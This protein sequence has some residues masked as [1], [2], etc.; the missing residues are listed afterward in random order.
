MEQ[1]YIYIKN[2]RK[3]LGMTQDQ[4]ATKLGYTDR[5]MIAKIESGVV[6]INVSTLKKIAKALDTNT[7]KISALV[8]KMD[9]VTKSTVKVDKRKAVAY[10]LAN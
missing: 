2:R 1:L 4:L 8:G 3:E 6:D 9:N 5:S 7:S 10:T